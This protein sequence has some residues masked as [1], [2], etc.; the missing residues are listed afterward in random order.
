MNTPTRPVLRWHGGKWLL[1]PWI[2]GHFP[3]HRVYVEPFGG[4]GSVLMRKQRAYAEVWNDLDGH[5]VNLF[6]V[7]QDNK[8]ATR[9]IYLLELTPFA[10]SEFELAWDETDDPVEMAR[11]LVIRS[12]MGFGSNAHSDMGKGHKT[13]GF[14]ANSSR[15]G[16]TPAH[17]WA[18]YPECL[19]AIVNRLRGV[20]IERRPALHVMAAHDGPDTLH[21][22]DP[23][24]LPET[25]SMRN[26]YDPKHQYR[27]ELSVD[28]HIELLEALGKLSGMVVL[29]GYP[30]PLY[31]QML[32]SWQRIE[33]PA[34]ADGAR[35]RIEVLWIN[36]AASDALHAKA[37]LYSAGYGTPLFQTAEAAE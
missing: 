12:F 29:S 7:L 3:A 8:T 5:V 2:I 24:Y 34:L 18:N 16:T 22:V 37:R 4:G 31:D 32:P 26:P 17:D 21:Y 14:R 11:R 20:T 30:A 6:R 35:P 28:D 9:L 15:S 36:P 23:P 27:H 10:R 13:T 19:R 25:R 33:R 1:A